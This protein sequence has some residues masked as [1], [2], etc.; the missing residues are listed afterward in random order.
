[1]K[2]IN[3]TALASSLLLLSSIV[4][5]ADQ[6]F[7]IAGNIS[8]TTDYVFRG[9]SQTL[10]D[11]AIQGGFDLNHESGIY[12]GIWASNVNFGSNDPAHLELDYIVGFGNELSNG[13]S[14][15]LAYIYYTYPG[16][17]DNLNYDFGEFKL[18]LG[19][20][21]LSAE[22]YYANDFFGGSGKAHYFGLGADFDLGQGF[23]AG[24]HVGRQNF[25]DIDGDYTD[26]SVSVGKTLVGVDFALSYTD[27][28]IDNNNTADGRVVFTASK[29]F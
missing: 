29:S 2:T 24:L 10:E 16:V 28:N 25:T 12:A 9:V 18:G 19:Y 20:Q 11:P 17:D 4:A 1:M 21:M 23:S 26:W 6:P 3:K 8:L 22:Y 5:A 14:Y 13:L 7:S 15:D 27:T